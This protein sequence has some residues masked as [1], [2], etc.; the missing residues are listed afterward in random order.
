MR[1][2]HLGHSCLLVE[3]ADVRVLLD[4]GTFAE[5]FEEVRDLDLVLVTHQHPDHLDPE[6]LPDLVR[7]NPRAEVLCDPGSVEPLAKVGVEGRAHDGPTRVGDLTVTPVGAVHALIHEEIPRI[8]NVGVRLDAPGEPSLFHPGDALDAEPGEVDV[9]AFPLSAPWQRSREMTAFLRRLDPP[10]AVPIHDGLLQKRGRDL[11]LSQAG[12]LGGHR[13][14][15]EDLAGR[16][17]VD[18]SP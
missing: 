8:P 3:L 13:T 17:A 1:V 7:E 12:A 9:L 15:I 14:R 18:L 4:P 6:R 2:T 16:G 5:G 10:V 11:Y